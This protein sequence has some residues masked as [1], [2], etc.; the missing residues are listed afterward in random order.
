MSN[1]TPLD[2]TDHIQQFQKAYF[3]ACQSFL[4][5]KTA[6][7]FTQA[8][9]ET[10]GKTSANPWMDAMNTWWA[11]MSND[12]AQPANDFYAKMLDQGKAF[13]QISDS[14]GSAMH[15][16]QHDS[17]DASHYWQGFIN[18]ATKNCQAAF[19]NSAWQM[20][21]GNWQH[22]MSSLSFFP[23]DALQGVDLAGSDFV[24]DNLRDNLDKIL[25]TPG[26]GHSREKQEQQQKLVKLTID[27]Q[28][29][30]QEYTEAHA[31]IGQLS[32]R[33]F[34]QRLTEIAE[35][36]DGEPLSSFKA[37]YDC[38]VDCCEEVYA[39]YV[40]TDKYIALQGKVVNSLMELK[41]QGRILVDEIVGSLNMPTR[42]EIDTLHSRF[43]QVWHDE[44]KQ[45]KALDRL[46][47]T[48]SSTM[49]DQVAQIVTLQKRIDALEGGESNSRSNSE[50]APKQTA[51]T[52]RR[53]PV[54]TK[55][56][57]ASS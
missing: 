27:Y 18:Q 45:M 47:D 3:D 1:K 41:N 21:L 37:V 24:A 12:S 6:A 57:G 39:E 29:G 7:Q 9:K 19:S 43:H 50:K 32:V 53:K 55:S 34:Q 31:E 33:K 14:F 36:E 49:N 17:H 22:V 13:L 10:G 40:M 4:P 30:L 26:V 54:S 35:K 46:T 15:D 44:K 38:W 11:A 23:G 48:V 42:R 51:G 52:T 28:E 56:T 8:T 25:M 16:V 5:E 20:P 2:W